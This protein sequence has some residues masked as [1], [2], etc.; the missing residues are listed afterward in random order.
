[1]TFQTNRAN[2][3]ASSEEALFDVS[4]L[5][6]SRTDARGVIACGNEVFRRVSGYTWDELIN[7]PHKIIRHPDMPKGVFHILWDRIQRGIPT[8]AYVK[9]RAKDGRYYWVFAV[10]SPV[11]GGYLSVRLK[12]TSDT[13]KDVVDLYSEA[14]AVETEKNVSPQESATSIRRKLAEAGFPELRRIFRV[15]HRQRDDSAR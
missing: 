6:F 3:V 15:R 4:E 11:E 14:L 9:N 5:F 7:A 8:G 2:F 1:M 13:L 12:P 10:V